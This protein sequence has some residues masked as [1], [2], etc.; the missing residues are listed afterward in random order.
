MED[1]IKTFKR[2]MDKSNSKRVIL[3]TAHYHITG[4]VH[5]CEDCNKGCCVNLTDAVMCSIEDAY[6]GECEIGTRYDWLHI[7]LDKVIAYSF[8]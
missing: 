3:I 7:N 4:N 6:A 2:I 8:V 5:D 1:N